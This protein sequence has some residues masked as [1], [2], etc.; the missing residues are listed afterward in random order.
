M[1][2]Q[3]IG[4]LLGK[5]NLNFTV[6][7][8]A[9]TVLVDKIHIHPDW[10]Y[11]TENYDAD[12]AILKFLSGIT[13][14]EYI[15]PICWPSRADNEKKF[16]GTVVGWGKSENK[17]KLNEDLP[18]ELQVESV[19]NEVCFLGD[20]KFAIISSNRTFCAGVMNAGPCFGDSGKTFTL[21]ILT[22]CIACLLSNTFHS[23]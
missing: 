6:E 17:E 23:Y 4:I 13:F 16:R 10:R 22:L 20:Y 3:D 9:V 2:P 1:L 5:H 21:A 7:K 8:S 19:I 11:H 14:S 18:K 12:I 15:F